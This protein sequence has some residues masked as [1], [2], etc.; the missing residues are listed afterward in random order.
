MVFVDLHVGMSLGVYV[1]VC[2]E[3][4]NGWGG[5]GG[6]GGGG[7]YFLHKLPKFGVPKMFDLGRFPF[8]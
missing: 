4:G 6:G 1:V 2:E 8:V 7:G 5:G 3:G